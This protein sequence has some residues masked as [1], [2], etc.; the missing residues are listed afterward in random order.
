MP[1]KLYNYILNKFVSTFAAG[2]GIFTVLFLMDQASRQIQQLAPH[3]SSLTD[4]FLSFLLLAPPLLAYTIP[5]AF[6]ISMIWTLEQMK[7]ERELLAITASGVPPLRL[8]TPFVF[9]SVITFILAYVVTGYLGPASFSHYNSRLSDMARKSF[10]NDLKPGVLF[11]GIPGTL[12]IVGDFDRGSGRIDGLLMTRSDLNE[13]ETGEII[14]AQS[15]EIQPPTDET[16]DLILKIDKGT[17]HPVAAAGNEYRSGSF[18][19]LVSRIQGQSP[20]T[21]IRA[22]EYLMGVSNEQLR[23]WSGENGNDS[24][25]RLS[26]MYTVEL[27]RRLAFPL[28]V[29]LY[30]FV[31]FPATVSTGRHGKIVAFTGSI[32]LFMIT[33]LLFSLGARLAYQGMIPAVLGAWLPVIF[34]LLAGLAVFPIYAFSQ[35]RGSGILGGT[36]P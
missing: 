14:I 31:V 8:L 19:S 11:D 26:A 15:G 10:M 33:F 13:A 20:R 9:S 34:L 22:K 5:L 24:N 36:R 7:Q 6:L 21:S 2:I 3:A 30:P 25:R 32:L 17:I 18:D 12:L 35:L 28:T 27:N 4:F 1:F 29:L 23:S 16:N